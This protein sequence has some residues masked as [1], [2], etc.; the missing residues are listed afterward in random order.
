M[1]PILEPLTRER[2]EQIRELARSSAVLAEITPPF[3]RQALTSA[4]QDA[5]DE[6][7]RLRP[8]DDDT[9]LPAEACPVCHSAESTGVCVLENRIGGYGAIAHHAPKDKLGSAIRACLN[10]GILF[11]PVV[12]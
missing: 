2:I 10:C 9:P 7:D 6:I 1:K 12:G 8:P 11:F 4:L 3:V 5:I